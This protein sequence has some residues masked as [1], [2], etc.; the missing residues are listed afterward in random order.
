M[1]ESFT[2]GY[3]NYMDRGAAGYIGILVDYY[4]T[5]EYLSEDYNYLGNM[6]LPG[7]WL[8]YSTGS[9]LRKKILDAQKEGKAIK[10]SMRLTGSLKQVNSGG[11]VGFVRGKSD[12]T[13]LIHSHYD[14]VTCGASE[15]ASGTAAVLALAEMYAKVPADELEKSIAFLLIDSHFSDYDTHDAVV[16]ELMG[17]QGNN[18][19]DIIANLCIEHICD[20]YKKNEEGG[21]SPTGQIESRIVFTTKGKKLNTIVQEEFI[22]HRMDRTLFMPA[23]L[24]GDDLCTDADMFYQE[25]IE[26]CSMVSGPI[27]LY[28]SDDTLDKI[29]KDQ[30]VPTCRTF[31]DILW[32]LMNDN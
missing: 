21:I 9:K 4:D 8:S 10:A 2:D 7:V 16:E 12:Q 29:P 3:F 14:S 18:G 13:I 19:G 17:G 5:A 25:G 15:D 11:V 1:G 22:R 30:L 28:S 24:L 20:E 32:R 23:D 26:V 31:S 6:K 27:Y